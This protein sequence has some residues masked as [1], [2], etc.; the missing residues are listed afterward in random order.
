MYASYLGEVS[1]NGQ[2]SSEAVGIAVDSA[3]NAYVVGSTDSDGFPHR[4]SFG[5]GPGSYLRQQAQSGWK[6]RLCTPRSCA[7]PAVQ[8]S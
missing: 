8:P 4:A 1:E 2:A 6:K 5:K 3:G 7:V